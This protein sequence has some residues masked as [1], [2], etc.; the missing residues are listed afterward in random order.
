M[1]GGPPNMGWQSSSSS[2]KPRPF[3]EAYARRPG[4]FLRTRSLRQRLLSSPRQSFW[5]PRQTGQLLERR[6]QLQTVVCLYGNLYL[7]FVAPSGDLLY[8]LFIFMRTIK[9]KHNLHLVSY[10][11]VGYNRPAC[12]TPLQPVQKFTRPKTQA[13]VKRWAASKVGRF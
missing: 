7:A 1:R 9:L 5:V 6:G 13:M 2:Q 4:P 3:T 10:H 11:D 12:K 8:T